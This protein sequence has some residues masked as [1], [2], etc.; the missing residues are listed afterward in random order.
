MVRVR[1]SSKTTP[2]YFNHDIMSL[3]QACTS[4]GLGLFV[5]LSAFCPAR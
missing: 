2:I 1:K 3:T 4:Y 5:T